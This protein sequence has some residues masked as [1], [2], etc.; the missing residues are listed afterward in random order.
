MEWR[1]TLIGPFITL[2]DCVARD[3]KTECARLLIESGA[4][5]LLK[6]WRGTALDVATP[7]GTT[8]NS[9]PTPNGTPP[10]RTLIA[11]TSLSDRAGRRGHTE[12][13]ALIEAAMRSR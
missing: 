5:L 8:T 10:H 13:V 3:G 7:S 4:N 12:I 9:P 6:N 1:L 11:R 2:S